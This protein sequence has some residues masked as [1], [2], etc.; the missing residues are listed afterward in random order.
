MSNEIL[1]QVTGIVKL[2]KSIMWEDIAKFAIIVLI[3]L[4]ALYIYFNFIKPKSISLDDLQRI[5]EIM[6]ENK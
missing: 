6:K 2:V 3:I 5:K 4:V 1:K